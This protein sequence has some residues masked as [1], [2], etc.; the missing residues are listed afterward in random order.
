MVLKLSHSAFCRIKT[1]ATASI[2][3]ILGGVINVEAQTAPAAVDGNRLALVIGQSEYSGAPLRNVNDPNLISDSL[4]TAGFSVEIGK[5]FSWMR[6]QWFCLCF[7]TISDKS[8]CIFQLLH[9]Y[10]LQDSIKSCFYSAEIQERST[11]KK[12]KVLPL[13]VFS[14]DL[15]EKN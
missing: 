6:T 1:S 5:V 4:A 7:A 11:L 12:K 9:S 3:F 15:E 10:L 8:T 14:A 13:L 2:L